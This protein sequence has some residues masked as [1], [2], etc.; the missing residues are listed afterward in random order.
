MLQSVSNE[1]PRTLLGSGFGAEKS[2]RLLPNWSLGVTQTPVIL[3][4]RDA[5]THLLPKPQSKSLLQ[6][7]YATLSQRNAPAIVKTA[8]IVRTLLLQTCWLFIYVCSKKGI[9]DLVTGIVSPSSAKSDLIPIHRLSWSRCGPTM[10]REMGSEHLA[11]SVAFSKRWR[12]G[13]EVP[14]RSK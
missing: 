14:W 1:H 6:P 13:T 5:L 12:H 10:I 3:M 8:A 2:G 11:P 4:S 9:S 7:A